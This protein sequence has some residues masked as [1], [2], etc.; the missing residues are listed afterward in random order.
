MYPPSFVCRSFNILGVRR[1][2]PNQPHMPPPLLFPPSKET[3]QKKTG[4]NSVNK[5][6]SC[7]NESL[8][9]EKVGKRREWGGGQALT[10]FITA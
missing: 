3:K 6:N 10:R 7:T 8:F 5:T 4:L 2:G 9:T 1:L